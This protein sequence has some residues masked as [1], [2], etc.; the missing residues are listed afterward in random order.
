M[1]VPFSL[2]KEYVDISLSPHETAEILTK[3]GLEV[4]SIEKSPLPFENVVVAKVLKTIP[5]PEADKLSIATVFDGSESFQVVC[6]ACNCK[7]NMKTA[8]AKIGAKLSINDKKIKI[9]KS[10]IRGIESRGMLCSEMELG[11]SE[12]AEGIV[13]FPNSYAEGTD[14]TRI[15]GDFIFEI[16]LTPNLGHCFSVFGIAREISAAINAPLKSP[17]TSLEEIDATKE[18]SPFLSVNITNKSLCPR[19]ACRLIK[20]VNIAPSPDWLRKRLELFGIRSVNNVV[21]VTNLV[22]MELGHPLHAFDYEKIEGRKILVRNATKGELFQTLDGKF[23]PLKEEALLICDG[24]RPIA[25]AGIMGGLNSE[26]GDSTK[27]VLLESAYFNSSNIRR[28]SKNLGIQTDSSKRFERGCDPNNVIKA[29]DKAASLIE[30][31][32]GGHIEKDFIDAKDALFHPIKI[33]C[34]YSRINAI[35]GTKLGIGE[36]EDIFQRLKFPFDLEKNETFTIHVPT[37]RNDIKYEIDLIEEVARIYGYENIEIK[38]THCQ[39][40]RIPHAPLF[41]FEK[42]L[43]FKLISEGLQ[44]FLNC[45]LISPTQLNVIE[46][47]PLLKES[48]VT[49]VNPTSVEQSVLRPSLLPGLL[50]VV[51]Y[52]LDR[53]NSNISG[54]EIGKIHFKCEKRYKEKFMLS[55]ILTGKNAPY[56]WEEKPEEVDFFHLKGLIENLLSSTGI[57]DYTLKF[58]SKNNLHPGRQA[59]LYVDDMEIG[60]IGEI[61]PSLLRK[62][63]ISQRVFFAELNVHDLYSSQKTRQRKIEEIPAFPGSERDWTVT[64][65]EEASIEEIFSSIRSI[66]TRFLQKVLLLDIYRGKQIG[67]DCRN[68]T[69][70]FTYKDKKKTLSQDIVEREHKNI[71]EKFS[72]NLDKYI[73]KSTSLP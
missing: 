25:L 10:K 13:A 19:Y 37:Y 18:A 34:R 6:G 11:L 22:L 44:E 59:S 65:K 2:L 64:M 12:D 9:K 50:Q 72:N 45:D 41:V 39:S 21:D 4:D 66:K 16:S 49:V 40:S 27:N 70:R 7:E 57:S 24:E 63:D 32:A 17:K 52:N 43:R 55:I 15:Y 1:K 26:V 38:P 68:I 8:Y 71:I 69:L 46:D 3:M 42:R 67:K 61:H 30:K 47:E 35:L 31:A 54:F 73:L 48:L 20:D 51:K 36:I 14:L 33:Q 53:K 60:A 29:L 23:H 56:H 5:H 28:T 62:L 58:S